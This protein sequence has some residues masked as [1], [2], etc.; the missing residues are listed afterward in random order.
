MG[1]LLGGGKRVSK[2]LELIEWRVKDSVWRD[3]LNLKNLG[4]FTR[5]IFL[6]Y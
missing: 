2:G 4:K 5:K 3:P 6:F 1:L